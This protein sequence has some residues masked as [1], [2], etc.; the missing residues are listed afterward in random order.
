MLYFERRGKGPPILFV[1]GSDGDGGPFAFLADSLSDSF[2]TILYDRRGNSRSPKISDDYS[3]DAQADDI[4]HLFDHL[5]IQKAYLFGTSMGS[6]ITMN[7]ILRHPNRILGAV[8]HEPWIAPLIASPDEVE[9]TT[10][11]GA[12]IIQSQL[13]PDCGA[14]EARLRYFYGESA[15]TALPVETRKRLLSN[16]ATIR[17]EKEQIAKWCPTEEDFSELRKKNIGLLLGRETANLFVD[18]MHIL[19]GKLQLRARSVPGGH[20]GFID[21][22]EDFSSAVKSILKDAHSK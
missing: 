19:E 15:F 18:L 10:T 8:L 14:L 21:Y 6:A 13:G 16:L 5:G 3:I 20:S 17:S 9:K 11:A 4:S 2:T 12:K 22:P 7:F 1:P